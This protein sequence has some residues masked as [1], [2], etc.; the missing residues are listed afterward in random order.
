MRIRVQLAWMMVAVVAPLA[1]V[2]GLSVALLLQ[3]QRQVHT[4]R[5]LERV[6]ALRLALDTELEA[7]IRLLRTLTEPT[8][9]GEAARLAGETELDNR[10]GRVLAQHPRWS[11]LA[12]V[13]ATGERVAQQQRAGT[14]PAPT[15]DEATRLLVL[16]GRL[17][18]VSGLVPAGDGVHFYTF[19]AVPE[20]VGDQVARLV[21]V[22]IEQRDWLGFL[23]S[24]P[25]ADDATLTLVDTN[26]LVIARTLNNERWVGRS[27][28][29]QLRQEAARSREGSF[30]GL[31]LEGQQF[32]SA[33]SRLSVAPWTLATGV[34]SESLRA[35]L[36]DQT[37]LMVGGLLLA[38]GVAAGGAAFMGRRIVRALDALAEV[39]RVTVADPGGPAQKPLPI[40]EAE[41]VRRKLLDALADLLNARTE[42]E[43][44]REQAVRANK[45][46]DEFLAMLAH[47][48]RNPLSAMSASVALLEARNATP[49]TNQHA[50]EVLK[51]QVRQ[52]SMLVNDLLDAARASSGKLSLREADVEL[53]Q[54]VGSVVQAFRNAG[55]TRHLAVHTSLQPVM[56][57]GDAMRLEQI[58]ANLLD[59][60]AKF[61]P[62]GGDVHMVLARTDSQAV[63]TVADTGAG[64]DPPLLRTL[65]DPFT[66]AETGL[67]RARGGLGLGLHVVRGLVELHGGTIE[68]SSPGVGRGAKFTVRLPV[69]GESAAPRATDEAAA[70]E[71]LP[72]LRVA[73]V[74]DHADVSNATAT[75]LQ[76]AGHQVRTAYDGHSGLQLLTD[77]PP[78][79]ALVDVGLPGLNGLEVAR[80]LPTRTPVMLALTAYGDEAMRAQ[81]REAGFDGFLQKPFE[82]R[83]FEQAVRDARAAR[84]AAGASAGPAA[85]PLT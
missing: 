38:A 39:S 22:G 13:T 79:V 34:P 28:S 10:L 67:D 8:T 12:V 62:A 32:H 3:T 70:P 27:A 17:P 1:L 24:Y 15:L 18:A 41:T 77:D 43:L 81:A 30:M 49:Q 44:A 23:R 58:V 76:M 66:Q 26:G 29:P 7:T 42:A 82:L 21:V 48:L 71:P 5:H 61:T 35:D 40:D 37:L 78:D 47:E 56:V 31:G 54:L 16:G 25:I 83:A 84:A 59:N 14:G 69:L 57:R 64:I 68:A 63:L 80:R 4:E 50:Q 45:G 2:A 74:E 72:P 19:V 33:F 51:R 73:L 9:T 53:S 52:M 55:R 85:P 46:K 20:V 75:L 65:F 36:R 60:A 6:R 11:S